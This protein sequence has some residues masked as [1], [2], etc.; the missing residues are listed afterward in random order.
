[1]TCRPLRLA[2]VFLAALSF[3]SF[4]ARAAVPEAS[5]VGNLPMVLRMEGRESA[6]SAQCALGSA[7]A[8]CALWATGADVA[9]LPGGDLA[10]NLLPGEVTWERLEASFQTS[11]P[12]VLACVTPA[13]LK[14]MLENGVS[15]LTLTQRELR[16]DAEASAFEGFPQAAGFSYRADTSAPVGERVLNL[17]LSGGT[18]LDLED[19]ETELILVTTD[20]LAAGD[21]GYPVLEGAEKA[22]LTQVEAMAEGIASGKLVQDY[23]ASAQVK[24]IGNADDSLA[25]RLPL[26]WLSVAAIAITLATGIKKGRFL[27]VIRSRGV[28]GEDSGEAGGDSTPPR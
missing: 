7:A 27:D 17:A 1:M 10:C 18:E 6:L 22:G 16:L 26:G 2:A 15:H 24:I 9:L 3:L 14:A 19:D 8:D 28:S 11:R 12:L 4:A 21:Y 13:E 5:P 20:N 23:T 25:G